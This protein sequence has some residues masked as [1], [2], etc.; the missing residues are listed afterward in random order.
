MKGTVWNESQ[1]YNDPVTLRKVRQIT[2]KGLVNTIPSYHTGQSFT[3]DGEYVIFI[4]IREGKS[5]LYKAHLPTGDITCLIEPIDGMGSLEELRQ[6]GN[7]KG[8]PIG[9]VIAPKSRWAYYLVGRQIRAV[10]IDTLE[11]AIILEGMD[12][13]YFIESMAVS[14]DEKNLAYLVLVLHPDEHEGQSYQIYVKAIDG[15]GGEPEVL[16][17]EEGLKAGH[18]MYNPVDPDLLMYCRDKGPSPSHKV[19]E[20]GRVWIYKLSEKRLTEVKTIEKQNFQTH[21][22]WT[23][24]GKGIV[25]HGIINDVGWKNNTTEG[26]WYIGLAGLDGSPIREY[27]FKDAKYY[28]HVSAM[29]GKNAAIIDGNILDGLLM[30]I[31]FDQEN[32]RIEIIA[33]HGTNFT[34]MTGQ[35]SHPHSISDPTGRWIVYNSAPSIIFSGARSDIY[36]V[37]VS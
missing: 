34:T 1:L 30:W 18:L 6:F 26:G 17:A 32:P 14:P 22:A 25:Y 8:I 12:E 11:E 2:T 28:G 5:A 37:E 27:S 16:I 20:Q 15:S 7:G 3:E 19:G 10:H 9:P 4:S 36:S 23:W 21:N 24:D 29:K 13:K 33:Q 31:Y 35:Y